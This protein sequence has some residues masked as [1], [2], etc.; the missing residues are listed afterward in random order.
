M[1]ANPESSVVFG[2]AVDLVQL[3]SGLNQSVNL[4]SNATSRIERSVAGIAQRPAFRGLLDAFGRPLEEVGTTATVVSAKLDEVGAAA[5]RGGHGVGLSAQSLARFSAIALEQVVPAAEGSRI[6]L[7]GGFQAVGRLAGGYSSLAIVGAGVAAVLAGGLYSSLIGSKTGA[8][9]ASE[10]VNS[11]DDKILKLEERIKGNLVWLE[12][13]NTLTRLFSGPGG[14]LNPTTNPPTLPSLPDEGGRGPGRDFAS[15]QRAVA[16]QIRLDRELIELEKSFKQLEDPAAGQAGAIALRLLDEETKK[17]I[18]LDKSLKALQ[19]TNAAWAIDD[20]L[21]KMLTDEWQ[22]T[23]D[24]IDATRQ[25]NALTEDERQ[26]RI[27]ELA[28]EGAAQQIKVRDRASKAAGPGIAESFGLGQ[29]NLITGLRDLEKL[30]DNVRGFESEI[31]RFAR[32]GMK[33]KDLFPLIAEGQGKLDEQIAAMKE[34]VKD[35]PVLLQK[36]IELEREFGSGGLQKK[37]DAMVRSTE[38]VQQGLASVVDESG[39]VVESFTG[40]RSG[41]SLF[42]DTTEGINLRL[43]PALRNTQ[44]AVSSITTAI[45]TGV[46][47]AIADWSLALEA[48]NIE[49]FRMDVVTLTGDVYALARAFRSMQIEAAAAAGARAGVGQ[50]TPTSPVTTVSP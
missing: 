41:I 5:Q 3:N 11:L 47:P 2:M 4:F 9:I 23:Q 49:A 35:S 16:E 18:E 40:A 50:T 15:Q 28:A 36:M 42:I 1:A 33:A 7:E 27:G 48:F 32:S 30:R 24:L 45:D 44:I 22:R 12:R 31:D 39:R 20:P 19:R 25:L 26:K 13:W 6:A 21:L 8:Q 37:L 29:G 10:G 46:I 38:G 34:R 43:T 17:V 14:G